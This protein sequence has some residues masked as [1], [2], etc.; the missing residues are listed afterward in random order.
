MECIFLI[1]VEQIFS[2]RT[3]GNTVYCIFVFVIVVIT[4]VSMLLYVFFGTDIGTA[5]RATGD[6]SQMIRA[7]GVSDGNMINFG[8]AI[9]NGLIALAGALLL[10]I[11]AERQAAS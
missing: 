2:N 1:T 9:S 8:L 7:L 3:T 4:M 11:F 10:R 6:N 5:M